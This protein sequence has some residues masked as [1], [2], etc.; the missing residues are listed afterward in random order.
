MNRIKQ[1]LSIL[2]FISISQVAIAQKDAYKIH[3]KLTDSQDTSILLVTYYG[4]TN[5]IVDTAFLEKG[6]YIFSGKEPLKGG[7]F[8]VVFQNKQYFEMIIDQEQ[9]FSLEA[10]PADPINT[11][12]IKGSPS[13]TDFYSYLKSINEYG[14]K[15]QELNKQYKEAAGNDAKQAELKAEIMKVNNQVKDIKI[16]FIKTHEGGL[17]SKI[18]LASRE[19]E[20]PTVLPLKADGTPDSSYIYSY[21]KEHYF[22]GF[23][24]ADERLLRTPIYASKI[25]RYF[26]QILVQRPDTLIK[27]S[28][29]IIEKAKSNKETYKYC[30]WYF[31]YETET[32]QIMGMDEVFVALG[33]KYYISGEAYWVNET[34]LS[35]MI[36]RINT[37]DRILIGN[38]APNLV[39]QDTLMQLQSLQDVKAKYTVVIFWDPDCGHCKTEVKA[40]EAWYVNNAE[41]YGVKVFSVCTD[42]NLVKWTN[43]IKEYK[44]EDW[45]NVDGPRSLT[46]N[47]HDLYDIISTPTIYLLDENKKILAKRLNSSQN[48]DYIVRNFEAKLK[49]E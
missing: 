14:K 7:I 37:L 19:P 15:D 5:Q 22:D 3:V 8:L 41:K 4:N 18:L 23:D 30:I 1:L 20:V 21:Y 46:E 45:V 27:E 34:V 28:F 42:T 6:Q 16:D 32:S 38:T 48:I 17:F 31:T 10:N 26:K 12:I 35:R 39:M 9:F 13:N 2:I 29:A 44:I 49:E 43:K 11:M 25:K 47:Y 40:L 33:K 36:K 24:F